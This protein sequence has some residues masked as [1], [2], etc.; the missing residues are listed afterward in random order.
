MTGA[1]KTV[2]VKLIIWTWDVL[3]TKRYTPIEASG[4]NNTAN[5]K[6]KP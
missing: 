3:A 2:S 6:G 1:L 4:W 5:I